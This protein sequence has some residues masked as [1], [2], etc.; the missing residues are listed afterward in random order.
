MFNHKREHAEELVRQCINELARIFQ[1]NPFQFSDEKDLHLRFIELFG[2]KHSAQE[3]VLH[4]EYGV[5]VHDAE[6]G[7]GRAKPNR[8]AYIDIVLTGTDPARSQVPVLG[9]E[10]D[11][12]KG[13]DCGELRVGDQCYILPKSIVS[14]Q[15]VIQHLKD[16]TWKIRKVTPNSY[17]LIQ[18]ISHSFS[19]R[20]GTGRQGERAKRISEITD[21]LRE[22]PG[23][24]Q[25][26]FT[27]VESLFLN[28]K[29]T[30]RRALNLP[31][32]KSNI[33]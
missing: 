33:P 18:F 21:P 9:I 5:M 17:F 12:A 30:T 25:D 16:D 10:M 22:F 13:H 3:F 32:L 28:G 23:I 8:N 11:L 4:R 24:D 20:S 7:R 6:Y 29:P 1:E 19:N 14:P 31:E 26:R 2:A 27:I 15:H